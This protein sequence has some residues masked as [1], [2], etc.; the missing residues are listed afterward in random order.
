MIQGLGVSFYQP[1]YPDRDHCQ[2]M[3]VWLPVQ[4]KALGISQSSERQ[5]ASAR[6]CCAQFVLNCPVGLRLTW[7]K[8]FGGPD[9]QD[10][11]ESLGVYHILRSPLF[12][13]CRVASLRR[14]QKAPRSLTSSILVMSLRQPCNRCKLPLVPET[15]LKLN[16]PVYAFHP[17]LKL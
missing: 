16:I 3:S 4:T 2:R 7:P 17:Y 6:L 15:K 9:N 1:P 8:K 10:H 13:N 12:L 14:P 5:I 11:T